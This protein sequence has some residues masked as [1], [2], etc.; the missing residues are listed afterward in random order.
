M[1]Q[2]RTNLDEQVTELSWRI[3]PQ[4]RF[5][6]KMYPDQ[7]TSF[8]PLS[9]KYFSPD[10]T[11][12]LTAP[13]SIRTRWMTKSQEPNLLFRALQLFVD[14]FFRQMFSSAKKFIL[15]GNLGASHLTVTFRVLCS[16]CRGWQL[17]KGEVLGFPISKLDQVGNIFWPRYGHL[18]FTEWVLRDLNAWVGRWSFGGHSFLFNMQQQ[19]LSLL[20]HFIWNLFAQCG[21]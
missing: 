16:R 15:F 8:D 21:L 17:R 6:R 19:M 7:V 14:A 10:Q 20:V 2:K 5:Q 3:F 13:S 12:T 18:N 4:C 11:L 1:L 9:K